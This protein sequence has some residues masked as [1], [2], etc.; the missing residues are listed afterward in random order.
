M[1]AW[2]TWGMSLAGAL[3]SGLVLG[4]CRGEPGAG[5]RLVLLVSIDTLRAD[6]LSCYGAPDG[7]T[8]AL[9][10]LAGEAIRFES[11]YAEAPW[12][13]PSHATL[14]T[15]LRPGAHA[16][17]VDRSLPGG[18]RTL[19]EALRDRG[20]RTAAWVASDYLDRP[21]GFDRGFGRFERRGHFDAPRTVDE[22]L[23]L[24][25][26][27]PLRRWFLFLHFFDVH[28]PYWQP[29]G[30][31]PGPA[32]EGVE[33]PAEVGAFDYLREGMPEG[34]TVP[35]LRR[36]YGIGVTRADREVGRLV[37][38]LKE[39]G[40]WEGA[41]V[42]VVSDHGEAFSERDGWLGHGLLPNEEELRVPWL[43]KL[44]RSEDKG[45]TT[46]AG[47]VGLVD[48]LPT[49]LDAVD[50]SRMPG[51]QGRPLL[52][53][54]APGALAQGEALSVSSATGGTRSL[55]T[56][57]WRYVEPWR[58]TAEQVIALHLRV[59][60]QET[61][62]WARR[63]STSA[64][65]YDVREDPAEL[66]DLLAARPLEAARLQES[67]RRLAE[68]DLSALRDHAGG[69]GGAVALD[70]ERRERLRSLGYLR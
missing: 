46:V 65:L 15:S 36:R 39:Q 5:P 21:Y 68:E 70:T 58:A 9:D 63:L 42:V 27:E 64:R 52:S 29:P 13:L 56:V 62:R 66:H 53:A 22:A 37:A 40:L 59:P 30:G 33:V 26:R 50:G 38:G 69:P 18:A 1:K 2:R 55:R 67:I 31:V 25:A 6:A 4:G 34:V 49:L 45:G 14:M 16:V 20:Y 19:A 44:P 8:P 51:A 60:A 48:V 17:A 61:A 10:A 32:L 12:T 43:L 54:L 47:P 28:G 11:A 3:L 24:L 35:E 23:S 7:S 57:E 41:L